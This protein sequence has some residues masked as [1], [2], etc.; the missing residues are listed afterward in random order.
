MFKT[1][2]IL[3]STHPRVASFVL[4]GWHLSIR[5]KRFLIGCHLWPVSAADAS[6]VSHLSLFGTVST[7]FDEIMTTN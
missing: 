2:L 7:A 1:Q 3:G 6:L 5:D 4:L